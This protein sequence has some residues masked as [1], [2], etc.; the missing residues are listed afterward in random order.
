MENK[1]SSY[2]QNRWTIP[3]GDCYVEVVTL[4]PTYTYDDDDL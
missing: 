2:A 1:R 4:L 3:I